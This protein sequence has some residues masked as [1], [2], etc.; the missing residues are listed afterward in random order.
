[1]EKIENSLK[2]PT[3]L[4]KNEKGWFNPLQKLHRLQII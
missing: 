2:K 4:E 3:F 1:M